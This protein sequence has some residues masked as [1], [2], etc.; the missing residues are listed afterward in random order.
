CLTL[1]AAGSLPRKLSPFQFFDGRIGLGTN[2]PRQ[3]GQT[4]SRTLSTHVAQNVHS[5]GAN[6]CF[7]R[8]GRQRLVAVLTRWS[9]FKH[10]GYALPLFGMNLRA[11][12]FFYN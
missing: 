12:P 9:E 2:P 11:T 1:V 10:A 8:I 3:F 5:I 4:F 6:P 7:K